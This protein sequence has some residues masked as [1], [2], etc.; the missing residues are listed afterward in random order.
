M[1]WDD[2]RSLVFAGADPAEPGVCLARPAGGG[3]PVRI[4]WGLVEETTSEGRGHGPGMASLFPAKTGGNASYT[5]TVSY[6]GS[7]I[8]YPSRPAGGW[9]ASSG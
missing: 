2:G 3:G 9:S 4:L 6:P 5:A 7:G 1:T 8:Q